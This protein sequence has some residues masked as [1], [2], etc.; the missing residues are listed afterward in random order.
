M[1]WCPPYRQRAD[2]SGGSHSFACQQENVS[3][4]SSCHGHYNLYSFSIPGMFGQQDGSGF[5]YVMPPYRSFPVLVVIHGSFQR[6]FRCGPGGSCRESVEAC[7]SFACRLVS[8]V[9]HGSRIHRYGSDAVG[10]NRYSDFGHSDPCSPSW[11]GCAGVSSGF[12]VCGRSQM[13]RLYGSCRC[14]SVLVIRTFCQLW[15]CCTPSV[16]AGVRLCESVSPCR[17]FASQLVSPAW[18]SVCPPHPWAG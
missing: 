6:N 15:F 12:R 8:S 18:C 11:P 14:L 7:S 4:W 3:H 1:W 13:H 16:A 10:G 5:R 9:C 17:R 2:A